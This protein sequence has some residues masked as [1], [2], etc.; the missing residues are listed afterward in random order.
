MNSDVSSEKAGRMARFKTGQSGNPGGR[1][2]GI[3]NPQARL[4]H[5]IAEKLPQIIDRLVVAALAGDVSAASLLLARCLPPLRP[6][7]PAL[8][9]TK[10]AGTMAE[11][12]EQIATEMLAGN[13]SPTAA[14]EL[15][16][17]IAT[18]ARV[19]E[20]SEIEQR[21]AALEEKGTK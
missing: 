15:M 13:L 2:K 10:K 3:P 11:R 6:E 7:S 18:Q 1:P 5:A 4:R 8:A 21:I 16:N 17:A 20:I 9:V 14:G 12:A 19:T